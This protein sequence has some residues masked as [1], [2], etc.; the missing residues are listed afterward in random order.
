MKWH[1]KWVKKNLI[2]V[3]WGIE[4]R[5]KRTRMKRSILRTGYSALFW[6][7]KERGKNLVIPAWANAGIF[8]ERSVL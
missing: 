3:I 8:K 5:G 7:I 4:H 2:Q 1:L 6:K